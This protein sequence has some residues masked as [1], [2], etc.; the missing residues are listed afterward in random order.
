MR[1]RWKEK[2]RIEADELHT[3]DPARTPQRRQ[4]RHARTRQGERSPC[5]GAQADEHCMFET[6]CVL[7]HTPFLSSVHIA[8]HNWRVSWV[9][10][11]KDN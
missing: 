1:E 10:K 5:Q 4:R 2:E 11:G 6:S 7:T 8:A 3:A 9:R